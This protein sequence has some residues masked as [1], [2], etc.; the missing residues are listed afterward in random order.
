MAKE[1]QHGLQ[2]PVIVQ[3]LRKSLG[4]P[5]WTNKD[6]VTKT[7]QSPRRAIF[8]NTYLIQDKGRQKVGSTFQRV[9]PSV[10]EENG[11]F[12]P[13]SRIRDFQMRLTK[14]FTPLL[15]WNIFNSYIAGFDY[16][17]RPMTAMCFSIPLYSTGTVQ[18]AVSTF[19]LFFFF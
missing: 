6:Q 15:T 1:Q 13:E 14:G 2:K 16:Y 5:I 19:F 3:L 9:A 12:L 10:L 4:C 18:F 7:L 11:H 8:V 17:H